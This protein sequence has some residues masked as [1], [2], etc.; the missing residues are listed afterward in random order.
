MGADPI[1]R[2]FMEHEGGLYPTTRSYCHLLVWAHDNQ[3]CDGLAFPALGQLP[4]PKTLKARVL[5]D[6]FVAP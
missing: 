5:C 6:P 2:N 1:R 4:G 3:V